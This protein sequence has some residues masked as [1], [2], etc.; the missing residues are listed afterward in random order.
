[1][2]YTLDMFASDC[3]DALKGAPGPGGRENICRFVERALEDE[4]FVEAHLG[5]QADSAREILYEDPEFGF[6]ILAHVYKGASD[7]RPHDHGP[8][9]AI[10]GQA[11]GITEMTDWRL[12][13]APKGDEPGKVSFVRSYVLEPGQAKF[14][15]QG[16]LHSPK[17]TGE[18]RLIRIEGVNME[19]VKRDRYEAV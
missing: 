19:K 17:R 6:V 9:W 14:Y 18:T 2:P 8:S 3:H 4:A 15:D 11:K 7:S 12:V 13:E 10:Y 16:V 5:P 1:M